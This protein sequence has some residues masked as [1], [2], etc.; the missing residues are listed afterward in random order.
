MRFKVESAEKK[1][2]KTF[3]YN[4][5]ALTQTPPPN[6]QKF[7]LLFLKRSAS[8]LLI[9]SSGCAVSGNPFR[10]ESAARQFQWL[11]SDVFRWLP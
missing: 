11:E 3:V 6:S 8:V 1:N 2:Q 9:S 5:S 10:L 7:L 4:I